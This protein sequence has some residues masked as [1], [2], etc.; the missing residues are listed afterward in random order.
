MTIDQAVEA[1]RLHHQFR[2]DQVRVERARSLSAGVL[3]ELARRG[4][5]VTKGNDQ[6]AA[7]CIVLDPDSTATF[8]Y[9]DPRKGGLAVGPLSVTP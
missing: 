8:G 4:H 5:R 9:A 7:N 2:P 6:G 1:P 3:S